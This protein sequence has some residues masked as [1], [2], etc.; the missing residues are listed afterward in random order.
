MLL[1]KHSGFQ[2]GC[3]KDMRHAKMFM[4]MS[5]GS[6]LD[7]MNM[8]TGTGIGMSRKTYSAITS[9]FTNKSFVTFHQSTKIIEI[10]QINQNLE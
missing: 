1:E 5:Q 7:I 9:C 4:K 2:R 10:N 6:Y 3:Y 8:I